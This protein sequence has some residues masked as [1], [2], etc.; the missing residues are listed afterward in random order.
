MGRDQLQE[1]CLLYFQNTQRQSRDLFRCLSLLL[2][3]NL[4]AQLTTTI[5]EC[6]PEHSGPIYYAIVVVLLQVLEA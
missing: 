3:V 4:Q 5:E 2:T 1:V 6:F